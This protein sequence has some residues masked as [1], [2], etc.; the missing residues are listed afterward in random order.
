MLEE[1]GGDRDVHIGLLMDSSKSACTVIS[2]ILHMEKKF[3]KPTK[4]QSNYICSYHLD[5]LIAQVFVL[6]TCL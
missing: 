6:E 3:I 2:V 4:N 1:A 5:M